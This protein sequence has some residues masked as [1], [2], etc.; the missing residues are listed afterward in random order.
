MSLLRLIIICIFFSSFQ[1]M[2][3][4]C[5]LIPQ[6][7]PISAPNYSATDDYMCSELFF[8]YAEHAGVSRPF[9]ASSA[10]TNTSSSNDSCSSSNIDNQQ[11]LPCSFPTNT[12]SQPSLQHHQFQ[13]FYHQGNHFSSHHQLEPQ[14]PGYTS[15]IV[16][17]QQYVHS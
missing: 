8:P 9:S 7:P 15:V 2:T 11:M 10:S 1:Q 16:D 14:I 4:S 5:S 3:P 12:L 6:Q 13:Q 17:T